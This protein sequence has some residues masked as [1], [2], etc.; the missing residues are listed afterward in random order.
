VVDISGPLKFWPTSP[1]GPKTC[2][3]TQIKS[4]VLAICGGLLLVESEV[5]H[6]LCCAKA[7]AGNDN[8]NNVKRQGEILGIAVFPRSSVD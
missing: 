3:T 8:R 2:G 5:G 6:G 7:M 1:A 4:P